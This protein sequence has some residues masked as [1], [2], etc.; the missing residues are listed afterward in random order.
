MRLQ[1]W[2]LTAML[3]TLFAHLFMAVAVG[4]DLVEPSQLKSGVSMP[5]EDI[6]VSKRILRGGDHTTAGVKIPNVLK[7][8][9]EERAFNAQGIQNAVDQTVHWT[10]AKIYRAIE[11]VAS[12]QA[13]DKAMTQ[14]ID[15][16]YFPLLYFRKKT[17]KDLLAI[18]NK[19]T[20]PKKRQSD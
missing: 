14:L 4:A 9:D 18:A 1:V 15:S 12:R 8:T 11:K 6:N 3:A 20:N 2:H 19:Q 17:P 5:A 13:A 16:V 10:H 7:N